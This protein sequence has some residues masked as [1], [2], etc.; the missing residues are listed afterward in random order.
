MR[1]AGDRFVAETQGAARAAV[2]AAAMAVRPVLSMVG[3]TLGAGGLAL[4]LAGAEAPPASA[5]AAPLKLPAPLLSGP[6]AVEQALQQRRSVR[7]LAATPLA[8]ADL[9]QLLWAA[10]GV[11]DAQG[12]R[13]APSAGALYPLEVLLVAGRVDGLAPGVYR[14]RPGEHALVK[15]A[16]GDVRDQVAAATRGQPWV[17]E[18]PALL[19]IAA[20][21][22]RT[23]ARYG[24]RADRYVQVEAGHA[25]QNVY[26]QCAARGWATVTVGAFDDAKL[27]QAVGLA[28][29]RMVLALMPV[30]HAR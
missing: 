3:R 18:A 21:V 8:L 9:A 7:R 2:H 30:G 24:A 13:T 20:D 17:A 1:C 16:A 26:L 6:V 25:A 19:V 29:D 15:V 4:L 22:A 23:A 10:Q 28:P 12:H 27:R 5:P 14:Y 11:T